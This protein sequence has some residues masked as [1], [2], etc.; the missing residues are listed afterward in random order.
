MYV[1]LASYWCSNVDKNLVNAIALN[2]IEK[3]KFVGFECGVIRYVFLRI[4][5]ICKVYIIRDDAF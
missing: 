4:L 2:T 3:F 1:L 5:F